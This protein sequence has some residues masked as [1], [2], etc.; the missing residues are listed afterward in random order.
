LSRFLINRALVSAVASWVTGYLRH[1]PRRLCVAIAGFLLSHAALAQ[2]QVSGNITS[3][4]VWRAAD[5]PFVIATDVSITNGARLTVEPGVTVRMA[6]GTNL[7]VARGAL[8]AQGT[9]MS[10]I[11]ITSAT[12][13]ANG[14]PKQGDW[15]R[16]TF[17]AGT[18]S[19]TTL[20]EYL[21]IRYG[22]GIRIESSSPALNHVAIKNHAGTAIS[23]DLNAS[24]SGVAL[25]AVGNDLNGISVPAGDITGSVQWQLHGIPYVVTAGEVSVGSRSTVSAITPVSI[26]QG[27]TLD[28]T[29]TGVRLSGVESIAF[30]SPGVTG[31]LAVGATD[32]SIPLKITA[33]A[34]QP[35]GSIGFNVQTAAGMVRFESGIAVVPSLS[36]LSVSSISPGN[37]RRGETKAFQVSGNLLDGAQVGVPA[38][39]GLVLSNLQT[40]RTTAAFTL[41]ASP[42]AM[43]GPKSLTVTN[44]AVP[45]SSASALVT[46]DGSMPQIDVSPAPLSFAADGKPHAFSLVLTDADTRDNTV[47]LTTTDPSIATVL[48]TSVTIPAGAMQASATITGFKT[49][50]TVLQI[51]SPTLATTSAPVY[52]ANPVPGATVGPVVSRVVGVT[53]RA[54]HGEF[55]MSGLIGVNVTSG[56]YLSRPVGVLMTEAKPTVYSAPVGVTVTSN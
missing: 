15:G 32:T 27:Q 47:S 25:S 54:D 3:D 6:V 48:P 10:P 49:G 39:T 45:N 16:L 9:A 7:V 33:S 28:A 8:R 19:A 36:T 29:I 41:T 38:N 56:G 21:D 53:T 52:I 23:M 37:I 22:S 55:I 26:Q 13:S 50:I 11:L 51:A 18:D 34:N 1:W 31:A 30:D 14:M 46:V 4:T 12:D 24:P 44:A 43:L 35:T 5:S 20:L 40:T 42:T 2:T 17:Q